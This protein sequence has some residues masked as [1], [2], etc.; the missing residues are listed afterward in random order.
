MNTKAMLVAIIVI[1]IVAVAFLVIPRD[2]DAE[3]IR[4][5]A[6]LPLS[7][8]AAAWGIPPKEAAEMAV[9]ELNQA[10][11]INGHKL[12][13]LVRDT[14]GDPKTA[15]S[16]FQNL[17][18]TAPDVQA[19]IG[20]VA[21]SSTLAVAPVAERRKIVLISPASTNPKITTAGDFIFRNVPTDALRGRVF[22]EYVYSHAG[23]STV[24]I[25]YVNNDAGVGNKD[26][27]AR[28]FKELGG[29]VV[30][31][32][33]YPQATRDVRTQL[34]N[35]KSLKPQA[36]MVVSYPEDTV[37]V[38]KQA[39]ELVPDLPLFFQAEAVEDPSVRQAAGA[40][41]E[42]VT[43]ILPAKAE[44]TAAETFLKAYE[45]R[46]GKQPELFA[47][48][49]Y[50]CLRLITDAI[51]TNGGQVNANDIRDYLYSV[52]T[53]D[54]ASGVI[55]FDHNGDVIKPMAVKKVTNGEPIVV[56]TSQ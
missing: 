30:G 24:V 19:V 53:Y 27:F 20:A 49:G 41:L 55:T 50:D 25:L 6:L 11:G 2:R 8:D 56:F 51:R 22:A 43:Y 35:A 3:T 45:K 17:L 4:V 39:H 10:G 47:A 48:E 9:E 28:R 44:G 26:A 13:L 40:D 36:L 52:N 38:L 31:E 34:T 18:A 23:V 7:G 15:V 54:G 37:V 12:E 32:E 1:A 5:G 16:A 21:S 14:A 42:G 29:T 46:Y 33:A